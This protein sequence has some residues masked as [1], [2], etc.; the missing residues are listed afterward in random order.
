MSAPLADLL[1]KMLHRNPEQRITLERIHE[2]HWFALGQYRATLAAHCREHAE[3]QVAIDRD[4]LQR[5][6]QA[7][8]DI[9][10]L[11]EQILTGDWTPLT[12]IYRQLLKEKL[13]ESMHEM[14]ALN[15]HKPRSSNPGYNFCLGQQPDPPGQPSKLQFTRK[16]QGKSWKPMIPAPKLAAQHQE[17]AQ[18]VPRILQVAA[19]IQSAQRRGSRPNALARP[20]LPPRRVKTL[21][22]H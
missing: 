1:R 4:V 12:A 10:L 3:A 7:Q 5:M 19:P 22:G 11:H 16:S 9:H 21:P 6:T 20:D 2:H 15:P 13:C 8:I 14:I 17:P 18:K